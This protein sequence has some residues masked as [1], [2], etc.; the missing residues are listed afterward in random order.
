MQTDAPAY[1]FEDDSRHARTEP[2]PRFALPAMRAGVEGLR[3]ALRHTPSVLTDWRD[4][5]T[6]LAMKIPQNASGVGNEWRVQV[7]ESVT[8]PLRYRVNTHHPDRGVGFHLGVSKDYTI[9]CEPFELMGQLPESVF[10]VMLG[11]AAGLMEAQTLLDEALS[12]SGEQNAMHN[13]WR[14]PRFSYTLRTAVGSPF[15]E[16]W[17]FAMQESAQ[18]GKRFRVWIEQQRTGREI[19][20]L[21]RSDGSIEGMQELETLPS[22]IHGAGLGMLLG[23]NHAV[24]RLQ[25]SIDKGEVRKASQSSR[26]GA[27]PRSEAD[28]EAEAQL[29]AYM[30]QLRSKHKSLS[31]E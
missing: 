11:A 3:E 18:R 19:R 31:E 25:Q 7:E 8:Y 23:I 2:G 16:G 9:E 26:Q 17:S 30:R 4:A 13:D 22:A 14:A 1:V 12:Q 15:A 28:V 10:G 5:A 6:L 21:L 27:V 29:E 20:L 24:R